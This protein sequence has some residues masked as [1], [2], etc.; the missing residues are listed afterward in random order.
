MTDTWV[1]QRRRSCIMD[2]SRYTGKAALGK[3][4]RI[5]LEND[6]HAPGSVDHSL[7][8]A[9]VRLCYETADCLYNSFTPLRTQ[10]RR[11]G[12]PALE[13][14]VDQLTQNPADLE[15]TLSA[16]AVFSS[17][18]RQGAPTAVDDLI[19]G[20]TEESIVQR[21]TVWCTDLARVSCILCQMAGFSSRLIFLYD[22]DHAY[23]GHAIIEAYRSGCWG[24]VDSTIGRVYRHG[25][26]MPASV[27]D[28]MHD[29]V[30]VE[31][32]GEPNGHHTPGQ[33]RVACV[34]N[35]SV[36]CCD[37]YD[38]TESRINPY[39]RAVL[40][41]SDKGW[42]EGLQWIHGEDR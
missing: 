35:Y 29:P 14:I 6:A 9:A 33:F 10:Y 11:G 16:V 39:T 12:R 20:G 40:E 19:L 5:M 37:R 38:Y 41:M 4:Y 34:S 31:E 30:L 28:L 27:W 42:P 1:D 21:G 26:G 18:L 32:N 8:D 13:T 25:T 2:L 36:C 3:A 15:A 17:G 23:S 22:T 7:M 24:A